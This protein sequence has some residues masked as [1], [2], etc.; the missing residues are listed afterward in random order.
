MLLVIRLS[1][2][3]ALFPART[4]LTFTGSLLS[5]RVSYFEF[6]YDEDEA[7]V[8]TNLRKH[9]AHFGLD[10]DKLKKTEKSTLEMELDLNQK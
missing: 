4:V 3:S 2:N 9:L 5:A 8:D 1:L 7:V 6:S 10:M